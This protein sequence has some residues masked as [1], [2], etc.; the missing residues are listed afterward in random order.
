M[1]EQDQR[2]TVLQIHPET[3]ERRLT[4][5]ERRID[6]HDLDI[7]VLKD[8]TT[9][10]HRRMDEFDGHLQ[11][12]LHNVFVGLNARKWIDATF[13]FGLGALICMSI[14]IWLK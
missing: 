4:L 3:V 9:A 8:A 2:D 5:V 13:L 14:M 11:A 7:A 1:N 12:G 6:S 10:T